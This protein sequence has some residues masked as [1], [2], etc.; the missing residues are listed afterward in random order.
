M[1]RPA[2]IPAVAPPSLKLPVVPVAPGATPRTTL[3][4]EPMTTAPPA[5]GAPPPDQFPPVVQSLLTAPV[6][7]CAA[8]ERGDSAASAAAETLINSR[9]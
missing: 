9:R 7:V 2:A 1:V 8:A 3:E 6:Q 5:T 4:F